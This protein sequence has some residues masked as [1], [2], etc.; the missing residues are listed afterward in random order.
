MPQ[1][2]LHDASALSPQ[3]FH[4]ENDHVLKAGAPCV[5]R[6][7]QECKKI[8]KLNISPP[9][10]AC[11]TASQQPATFWCQSTGRCIPFQGSQGIESFS[12]HFQITPLAEVPAP[13]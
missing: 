6:L 10:S 2:V 5:E 9:V 12:L 3:H 4:H 1:L 7:V 11:E 13:K 8:A